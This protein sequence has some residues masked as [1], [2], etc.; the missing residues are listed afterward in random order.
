MR[1]PISKVIVDVLDRHRSVVDQNADRQRQAAQRH[2][3]DRF[4]EPRQSSQREQ[5]GERYLDQDNDRRAPTAEEGQDHQADQ[6]CRERSLANDAEDCGFDEDRLIADRAQIEARRQ[7]F[8]HAGQQRFDSLDDTEC[9]S[10]SGLEDR[11][12][13]RARAVNAHEI[14]LRRRALMYEG[15]VVYVDDRAVDLLHRQVVDLVDRGGAG[16]KHHVPVELADLL[17]AGRQD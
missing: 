9:G 7:A 4:A 8:L 15:D 1:L 10:R 12:Q 5:Y 14:G 6:R 2:H 13:D 17:V 3:V 11:H 16:V